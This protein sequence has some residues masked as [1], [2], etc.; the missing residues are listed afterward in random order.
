MYRRDT[1]IAALPWC[2]V[3]CALSLF[4]ALGPLSGVPHVTDEVAYTLQAKL[5]AAG[6]RMGPAA[7]VP[8]M[9]DYPF[10]VG[11]PASYSP[12][13]PG[14]PALLAVGEF[15]GAPWAVNLS[16]I[17]ISEPTRPY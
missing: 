2:V 13:P 6:M 9:L 12:F 3:A 15:V 8:S 7:D 5:F 1:W 16:L 10:W 4:V 14:W 11:A 17:H